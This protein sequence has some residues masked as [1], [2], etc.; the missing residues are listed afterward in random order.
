MRLLAKC[1]RGDAG[2]SALPA[3]PELGEIRQHNVAEHRRHGKIRHQ[4]VKDRL[5]GW[6]VEG[7]EGLPEGT[8][9][10][11]RRRG[12]VRGGGSAVVRRSAA[13]LPPHRSGCLGAADSLVGEVGLIQRTRRASASE[14]NRKPPAERTG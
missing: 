11:T 13:V 5:C 2:R 14:Y 12:V 3:L 10:L 4:P 8:G 9:Q 7:V 1:S 6:L